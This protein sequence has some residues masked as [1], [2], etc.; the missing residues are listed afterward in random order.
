[1]AIETN[2]EWANKLGINCSTAITCVKPSGT[3]SQLVDS[4]SGIHPRFSKYYLRTVRADNKDPLTVFIKEQGVPSEP[5]VTKPETT[6][7]LSFP[8]KSPEGSVTRKEMS[9]LE[10]LELWSIYQDYWCEHKPSMTV[11]YK[12]NEFLEVCA[13]VYRNFDKVSGVSFL[14][15]SDHVYKQAPYQEITE[16]QYEEAIKSFPKIDWKVFDKYEKEDST[17]IMKEFSCSGDKCELT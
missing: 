1:V 8:Q 10:Q 11:Y 9:A 14:P 3:V 12:D 2:K 17:T 15:F 13:W 4:A 7:V 5:D 16:E 6:T